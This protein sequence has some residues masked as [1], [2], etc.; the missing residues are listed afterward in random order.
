VDLAEL[1][2]PEPGWKNAFQDCQSIKPSHLQRAFRCIIKKFI[3]SSPYDVS[4]PS[5]L[6]S[7]TLRFQVRPSLAN[8]T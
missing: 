5:P 3:S 2:D 6:N 4:V 7:L 1:K 8:P